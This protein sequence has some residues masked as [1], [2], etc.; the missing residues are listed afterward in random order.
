MA[1]D[2]FFWNHDTEEPP[3]MDGVRFVF[4]RVAPT[5]NC[6]DIQIGHASGIRIQNRVKA[7]FVPVIRVGSV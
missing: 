7:V 4:G 2:D 6:F 3:G 1:L 5:L